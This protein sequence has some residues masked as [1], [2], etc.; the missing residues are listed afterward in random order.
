MCFI[1]GAILCILHSVCYNGWIYSC[2]LD[3]DLH[4]A[5][6]KPPSMLIYII[7]F[8]EYTMSWI[9]RICGEVD[10]GSKSA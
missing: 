8:K 7:V 10:Y 9:V 6:V 1:L 5:M 2:L 3:V 4:V